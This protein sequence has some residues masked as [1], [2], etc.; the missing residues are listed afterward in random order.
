MCC[1][2]KTSSIANRYEHSGSGGFSDRYNSDSCA[3]SGSHE[4]AY[5]FASA[6]YHVI[7]NPD[8]PSDL[9]DVG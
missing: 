6:H 1:C 7:A 2:G 9:E 3:N 4:D 5:Y 8:T